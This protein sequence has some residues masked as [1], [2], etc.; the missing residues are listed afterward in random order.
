MF[1]DGADA[2]TLLGR[3]TACLAFG[4]VISSQAVAIFPWFVYAC[5]FSCDLPSRTGQSLIASCQS[6]A[7][8]LARAAAGRPRAHLAF[9][10][11][12]GAPFCAP[13]RIQAVLQGSLV[14]A[15]LVSDTWVHA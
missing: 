12:V 15:S 1:Q 9:L 11:E 6:E 8:S 14:L 5:E 13:Q 3:S 2:K 7:S 4:Y 10:C